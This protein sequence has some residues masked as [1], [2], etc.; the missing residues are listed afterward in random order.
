MKISRTEQGKIARNEQESESKRAKQK[1]TEQG[2]IARNE[3]ASKK[4]KAK[5]QSSIKTL[6]QPTNQK[7]IAP[8]GKSGNKMSGASVPRTEK[9]QGDQTEQIVQKKIGSTYFPTTKKDVC[10]I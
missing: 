8:K 6:I 4:A 7:K 2:K 3:Q 1:I 9:Q 10:T 5:H